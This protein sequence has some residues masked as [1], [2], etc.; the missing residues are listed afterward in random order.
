MKDKKKFILLD[1]NILIKNKK[2]LS[3]IIEKNFSTHMFYLTPL[4]FLEVK[5]N[6]NTIRTLIQNNKLFVSLDPLTRIYYEFENRN[7]IGLVIDVFKDENSLKNQLS[8]QKLAEENI[9]KEHKNRCYI[10]SEKTIENMTYN[11][12][13][14]NKENI[15]KI[16]SYW[17]KSSMKYSGSDYSD[18]RI[19]YL[20]NEWMNDLKKYPHT[21]HIVLCYFYSIL[22]MSVKGKRRS[23]QSFFEDHTKISDLIYILSSGIDCDVVI[24]D[25]VSAIKAY[26]YIYNHALYQLNNKIKIVRNIKDSI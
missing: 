16:F 2:E 17:V 21:T 13:V 14:S 6:T 3:L 4:A 12:I 19:N 10:K 9:L 5:D 1:S 24:M 11:S 25:D 8:I 15:K 22:M 26:D 23:H 18:E 7:T 20:F